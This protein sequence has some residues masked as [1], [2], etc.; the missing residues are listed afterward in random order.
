MFSW[1]WRT[2]QE[3]KGCRTLTPTS[4]AIPK[5]R[6]SS[7]QAR[8]PRT[9]PPRPSEIQL[10]DPH[11]R[12]RQSQNCIQ[13]ATSGRQYIG[14]TKDDSRQHQLHRRRPPRP[15]RARRRGREPSLE[16]RT[17]CDILFLRCA[18]R[19]CKVRSGAAGGTYDF[20]DG[21]RGFR[22]L[23]H[24]AQATDVAQMALHLPV[25]VFPGIFNTDSTTTA[26]KKSY[27]LA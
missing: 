15:M 12:V 13:I 18:G 4:R 1:G 7:T 11:R 26:L 24:P 5:A 3:K 25:A 23:Q 14:F 20:P 22:R 2:Q 9:A 16:L 19:P 8:S 10:I 27:G 21:H 17:R 6:H